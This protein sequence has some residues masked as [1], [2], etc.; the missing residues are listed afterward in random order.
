MPRVALV[1]EFRTHPGRKGDFLAR[2]A[3]H[4]AKVLA[5][6]PGCRQFHVLEA[7]DEENT[8][9]LYEVYDDQKALEEHAGTSYFQAY[10][11]DIDPMIARR[12]RTVCEVTEE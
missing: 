2:L 6:E 11:A 7:R 9:F 12:R 10:R 3:T 4:R 1:V 5:N 8:V